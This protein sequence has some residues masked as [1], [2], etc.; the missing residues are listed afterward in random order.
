MW[1][2][3]FKHLFPRSCDVLFLCPYLDTR[4]EL[5][6]ITLPHSFIIIVSESRFLCQWIPNPYL[7]ST[8]LFWAPNPYCPPTPAYVHLNV[9]GHFIQIRSSLPK[10]HP[11]PPPKTK[12]K[13]FFQHWHHWVNPETWESSITLIFSHEASPIHTFLCRLWS[14]P[15]ST[16]S[17][18]CC[19]DSWNSLWLPNLILCP[20]PNSAS[21]ILRDF[22]EYKS[23]TSHT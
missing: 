9:R 7:Q 3:V 8:F 4:T 2:F 18:T 19:L 14:S 23:S 6:L 16:L 22:L 20:H 13:L 17:P 10:S 12:Q 11:S 21:I 5:I 1:G 15:S